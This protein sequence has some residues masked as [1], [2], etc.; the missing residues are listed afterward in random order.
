MEIVAYLSIA[1]ILL[2][3]LGVVLSKNTVYGALWLI[4]TFTSAAPL[5]VLMGAEFIAMITIIL[6]VGAVAILF[7]F[8]VMMMDSAE[9]ARNSMR[10]LP[11]GVFLCGGLVLNLCSLQTKTNSSIYVVTMK[12]IADVLYKDLSFI[13]LGFILAAAAVGVISMVLEQSKKINTSIKGV[14]KNTRLQIVDVQVNKGV[15]DLNYD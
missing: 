4:F 15:S 5:F 1:F 10:Y 7:L 12:D 13:V 2:G 8:V 11:F 9:R 14:N 3:S 6:Y